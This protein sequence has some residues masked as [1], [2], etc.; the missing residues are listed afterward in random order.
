MLGYSDLDV[1]LPSQTKG[2]IKHGVPFVLA[3][4]PAMGSALESGW[5]IWSHSFGVNWFFAFLAVWVWRV[6]GG[7]IIRSENIKQDFWQKH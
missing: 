5:H 7:K 4:T 3:I 1:S 2:C 6:E